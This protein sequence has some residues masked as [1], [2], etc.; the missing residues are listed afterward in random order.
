[1]AVIN[2]R[3]ATID[4]VERLMEIFLENLKNIEGFGEKR[5]HQIKEAAKEFY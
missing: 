3:N 2:L 4:T 1:M 5:A